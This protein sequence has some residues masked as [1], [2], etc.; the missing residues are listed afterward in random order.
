MLFRS[1]NPSF[2]NDPITFRMLCNHTSS[3]SDENYFNYNFY[4][5]GTD[6]SLSLANMMSQFYTTG[7]NYFSANNFIN[8]KPGTTVEYTNMGIALMGYLV[9]RIA[10]NHLINIATK[11]FLHR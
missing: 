5:F 2:P 8:T 3:I 7:G 9:E 4:S 1:R 11:I 10:Q 6:N